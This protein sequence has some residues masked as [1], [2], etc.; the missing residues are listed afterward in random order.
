[1]TVSVSAVTAAGKVTTLSDPRF[2]AENIR[3]ACGHRRLL[4]EKYDPSRIPV[5]FVHG[6]DGSPANFKYPIEHLDRQRFQPWV[7]YYPSSARLGL[8][9]DH[10][11][12]T[13]LQVELHY[14]VP[15][16]IVVAQCAIH[17]KNVMQD[18]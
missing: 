9:A 4:L 2:A 11:A 13:V 6:T 14:R 10:L 1:M 12:Q 16:L 3:P 15:K 5:L 8:I 18:R 7:Y 17:K